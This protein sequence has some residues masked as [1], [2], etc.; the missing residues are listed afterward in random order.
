MCTW[1]WHSGYDGDVD[2]VDLAVVVEDD[3]VARRV[4]IDGRR[5]EGAARESL[6]LVAVEAVEAVLEQVR[7]HAR[8]VAQ[9]RVH[10][11][12]SV[13]INICKQPA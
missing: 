5:D 12:P 4:R 6:S 8:L 9:Q 7:G 3:A 2:R 10:V 1:G 11:A 13:N